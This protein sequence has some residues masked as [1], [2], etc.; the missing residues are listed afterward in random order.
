MQFPR[1]AQFPR[2]GR[3]YSSITGIKRINE[4]KAFLPS[5]CFLKGEESC[6]VAMPAPGLSFL[7]QNLGN[8]LIFPR[9]IISMRH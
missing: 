4:H 2:T 3:V 1:A 6:F 8:G 5:L 9:K 7:V